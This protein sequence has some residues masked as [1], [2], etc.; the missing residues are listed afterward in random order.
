LAAGVV[1]ARGYAWAT[2]VAQRRPELLDRS[3]PAL[4]GRAAE[5]EPQ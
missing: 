1:A 2:S 5:I 3:W 4:E